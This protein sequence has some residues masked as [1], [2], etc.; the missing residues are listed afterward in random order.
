MVDLSVVIAV[1]DEEKNLP[2]LASRLAKAMNHLCVSY[3]GIF[4]TDTNGDNTLAVLKALNRSDRRLKTLKLSTSSGQYVA[5]MA[6][7]HFSRGNAVVT[8]DGDLQDHPEDIPKLYKKLNEGYDVVYATKKRKDDSFLRNV[9]SKLFL[10]LLNLLSDYKLD[11]NTSVFRIMSRR[12]VE[13]IMKFKEKQPSLTGISSLIGFPTAKVMVNSGKRKGGKT[14]YSW[15]KLTN[16]AISILLSFSTKPIR[17]I[18]ASGFI[19]SGLSFVYLFSVVI[20]ALLYQTD[21][22]GYPTIVSLITFLGGMQLFAIGV[23]GEYIGRV[24][25]EVKKRPLYIVE[26]KIGDFE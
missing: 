9:F 12:T 8:M 13:E 20:R 11:Q 24:F 14:K 21:V 15:I 26:D 25:I 10:K 6:G 7:L 16:L 17:V 19:V 2:E 22:P 3:E 23:I 5:I 18:S 1:K 4:V